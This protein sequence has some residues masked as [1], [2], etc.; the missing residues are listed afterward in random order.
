MDAGA[1][2]PGFKAQICS[3]RG[4]VS[5]LSGHWPSHLW[6]GR[7]PPITGICDLA[8]VTSPSWSLSFQALKWAASP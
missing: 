1:R 2:W 6:D 7:T 8:K 5:V 3:H 4:Q